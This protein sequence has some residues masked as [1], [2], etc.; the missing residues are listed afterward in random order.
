MLL[1]CKNSRCGVKSETAVLVC[2]EK[3]LTVVMAARSIF[4]PLCSEFQSVFKE[5]PHIVLAV[6]GCKIHQSAPKSGIE[7]V[8]Q[9]GFRE[10]GNGKVEQRGDVNTD[11]LISESCLIKN[12]YIHQ[13]GT[14]SHERFLLY[15][16]TVALAA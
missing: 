1:R 15:T 3:L 4:L 12:R 5:E 9:V 16:G 7:F 10:G 2:E 11:D 8:H 6:D 13:F 14:Q